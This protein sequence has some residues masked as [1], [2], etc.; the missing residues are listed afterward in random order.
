MLKSSIKLMFAVL[1]KNTLIAYDSA[2]W[3]FA[4]F[5]DHFSFTLPVN[6]PLICAFIVHAFESCHLQTLLV[7]SIFTRIVTILQSVASNAILTIPK[8]CSK[9]HGKVAFSYYGLHLWSSLPENQGHSDCC[10]V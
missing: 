8:V 2:W 4:S 7:A 6:I 1:F 3:F 5:F 9:T 10:C